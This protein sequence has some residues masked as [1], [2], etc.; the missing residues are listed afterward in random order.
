M[1]WQ[2]DYPG[3]SKLYGKYLAQNM[4]NA[5]IGVLFQNDA[6]GKN[7]YA[8]LRVG[9]GAKK[10][11][12]VDAQSYDVDLDDV[13][14]QV[15]A[16]KA[17]RAPLFVVF[18]TPD[19]DDRRAR[20]G[21]EGRLE[22]RQRRS[23]TTCR[24]THLPDRRARTAATSTA[25]SRRTTSTSHDGQRA[26]GGSEARDADHLT[27]TRLRSDLER[28]LERR[29][30]ARCA[31]GRSSYALKKAGKNPTR[32]GL[33]KALHSLN[34]ANPFS[35]PGM[36]LTTT[37][38]D[39][40]PLEQ[41]IFSKW[42]G[43]ATGHWR[44]VRQAS[45]TTSASTADVVVIGGGALG[46]ATAFHLRRLGVDDV[47]LL[48]RDSLASGSTSEVGGR[49]PRAVRGRAEHPH[50][51]ALARASSRRM[52]TRSRSA[53]T[54]TSSCSTT[55]RTW[56]RFRAALELQQR[57]GVPSRE[58]T[59]AEAHE[60]VPQLVVGR[61]ARARRSARSTATRRRRRVVQCYARA[62]A[63]VRAGL[64]GRPGS[65]SS[66]GRIVGRRDDAPADR[67]RHRRLLRR[68]LVARGRRSRR[69]SSC[70]WRASRARCGSRRE[71]G[72][73]PE[74]AAADDRLLD[75]AS[76]STARGPGLAFGGREPRSRTSPRPP[77]TACPCWPSCRCRR[78]GGAATSQRPTGTRSSARP[79]GLALPLRHRLLRPR[80][81]AGARGRRARGGARRRPRADA[82]PLALLGQ[83]FAAGGARPESV[84]RLAL[85]G[86][87]I[88]GLAPLA[89][90][91]VVAAAPLR[92]DRRQIAMPVRSA[93]SAVK[94][95]RASAILGAPAPGRR[96]AR[97]RRRPALP[98]TRVLPAEQRHVVGGAE[99]D[100]RVR[101]VAAR[102]RAR[103]TASSGSPTIAS[104]RGGEKWRSSAQS[105][106]PNG[107]GARG[108]ASRTSRSTPTA[109]RS[110][111]SSP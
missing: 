73:L 54:A 67:D 91:E 55:R 26:D 36:K 31:R 88:R 94:R 38:K 45:T 69:A 47:V 4:P 46:A 10:S 6:Y 42:T 83:R 82:R 41:L 8:G 80:L 75:A 85:C 21:D 3:E 100:D 7:Y 92:G 86:A 74:R 64:R 52:A 56:R 35:Y 28:R 40:F 110:S 19:A 48:E 50:R 103:A 63:D 27:S 53:R 98:S 5:K 30:R 93:P 97:T 72:G 70:R 39:N 2:P 34:V 84:R 81:P 108:S 95:A 71:D 58:L 29:L 59:P 90:S 62:G 44:S 111:S 20:H 51:A 57:L 101:V 25:S 32:A 37:A 17:A 104:S 89:H 96:S 87:M 106:Q 109:R 61:P 99:G 107:R 77:R 43:G 24:R 76:T 79:R 14:Q 18:A 15:L 78:R 65:G 66:D 23:S 12:I 9:L 102:A 68:R 13:A 22:A 105:A 60:L 49:D 16:L 33:M 11:N 1:G